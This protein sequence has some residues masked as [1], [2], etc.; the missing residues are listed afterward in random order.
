MA[1]AR[2]FN[3]YRDVNISYS[4]TGKEV[5]VDA[6]G[7]L[8]SVTPVRLVG[9]VFDG[10]TKDTNFWTEAVTGTGSVTQAGESILA[11]GVTANSTASYTSVRRARKITGASNQFKAVAR[12]I[13]DPQANNIRRIGC[14]DVKDGSLIIYDNTTNSGAQIAAIDCVKVLGCQ[15]FDATFS[16]GLTIVNGSNAKVTLVYE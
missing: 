12:L 15:C 7:N 9:T 13:T 8:K 16:N 2:Q 4:Q 3:D 1:T 11:T 10:T 6:L 5:E 14:Y